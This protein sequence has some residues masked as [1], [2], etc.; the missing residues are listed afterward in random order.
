MYPNVIVLGL[1]LNEVTAFDDVLTAD[2]N[3]ALGRNAALQV[4]IGP[5]YLKSRRQ[6]DDTLKQLLTMGS[7][8]PEA[9]LH[10]ITAMGYKDSIPLWRRLVESLPRRNTKIEFHVLDNRFPG[11]REIVHYAPGAAYPTT[12]VVLPAEFISRDGSLPAGILTTELAN[13]GCLYI[14]HCAGT[15]NRAVLLDRSVLLLT[16]F[17]SLRRLR[18]SRSLV[19]DDDDEELRATFEDCHPKRIGMDGF[20]LV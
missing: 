3:W 9:N 8:I 7:F 12:T 18:V 13:V 20:V 15:G 10:T 2:T 6:E 5:G 1:P 17:N 19:G 4:A 14:L 11:F 16:R